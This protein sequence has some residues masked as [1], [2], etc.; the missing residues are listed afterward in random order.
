M[1]DAAGKDRTMIVHAELNCMNCGYEMGDIEGQ[2]NAPIKDLLFLPTH[3]G[4]TLLV[5]DQGRLQC[6]R[7]KGRVLPYGVTPV[8]RP[9]DPRQIYEGEIKESVTRG[10]MY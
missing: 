10:M 4:D 3:Q 5:D 8:A 6:P 9:L 1:R 2:K 7:C